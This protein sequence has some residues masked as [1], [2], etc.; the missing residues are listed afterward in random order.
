M[1][2][3]MQRRIVLVVCLLLAGALAGCDTIGFLAYLFNPGVKQEILAE[4]DG[5]DG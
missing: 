5:L 3:M 1:R 4:Y 2:R